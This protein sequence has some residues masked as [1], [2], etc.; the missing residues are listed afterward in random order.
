MHSKSSGREA[1]R[2]DFPILNRIAGG[3]D[4]A[5]RDSYP[6]MQRVLSFRSTGQLYGGA[7]AGGCYSP[8]Q[9]RLLRVWCSLQACSLGKDCRAHTQGTVN[10][11]STEVSL[12]GAKT[13][14]ACPFLRATPAP[15]D[16][17][18]SQS[19]QA[20]CLPD[21]YLKA[22]KLLPP[23]AQAPTFLSPRPPSPAPPPL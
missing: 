8:R 4:K 9:A 18:A 15:G 17:P 2:L 5:A 1:R 10:Q 16:M 19:W 22:G 21:T 20:H 14:F 13:E 3:S 7:C 11:L 6:D 12:L 23:L